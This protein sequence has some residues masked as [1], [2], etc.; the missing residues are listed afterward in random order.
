M[1]AMFATGVVARVFSAGPARA[2]SSARAVV[3]PVC[4]MRP[5]RQGVQ[6]I[7]RMTAEKSQIGVYEYLGRGARAVQA[8][9]W[10]KVPTPGSTT[11]ETASVKIP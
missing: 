5:G 7:Y 9:G 10:L 2:S 11:L 8:D 3:S 4:R 6:R 1:A